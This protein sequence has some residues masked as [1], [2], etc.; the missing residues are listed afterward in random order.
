MSF[1]PLLGQEEPFNYCSD[2][3]SPVYKSTII[4]S[5]VPDAKLLQSLQ[6][7]SMFRRLNFSLPPNFAFVFLLGMT[8]VRKVLG[9]FFRIIS[10]MD[11]GSIHRVMESWVHFTV[12]KS[13]RYYWHISLPIAIISGD[14]L[15]ISLKLLVPECFT[16]LAFYSSYSGQD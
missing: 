4:L 6:S 15:R 13:G 7:S 3:Q 5:F 2:K 12:H 11:V 1:W 9:N 16:F 8:Q 14:V 10:L